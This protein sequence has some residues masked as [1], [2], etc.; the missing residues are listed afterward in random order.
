MCASLYLVALVIWLCS[1]KFKTNGTIVNIGRDL[2]GLLKSG[3]EGGTRG[4]FIL[5]LI[6]PV[7]SWLASGM[8]QKSILSS[9]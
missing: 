7:G 6:I 2:K 9:G 8:Y 1:L 3:S 4:L 5:L